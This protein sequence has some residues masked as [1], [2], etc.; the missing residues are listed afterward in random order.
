MKDAKRLSFFTLLCVLSVSAVSG[1]S[2][3]LESKWKKDFPKQISWYVRTSPGILLVKAGKDLI[4]LDG[5][6]GH[7]LWELPGAETSVTPSDLEVFQRGRNLIEVPGMGVLLLNRVKLSGNSDGRLVALNLLTGER[8]WDHPQVDNLMTALPLQGSRDI[9]IVSRR[10]QRKILVRN[11]ILTAGEAPMLLY[12]FR[13]EFQR[14]DPLTGKVQWSTEYPRIFNPGSHS[15]S[16]IGN[17]LFLDFGNGLLGCVDLANGKQLW[18]EGSK[19]IGGS[20]PLSLEAA[21]GNVIYALKNVRAVHPATNQISWQIDKLG[22][23]TG[24]SLHEDMVFAI[25]ENNLAAVDAKTGADRW[26][27]KTHGHTTNTLWDRPTDTIIYVDGKGLHRVE[28]ATGKS[29]LDAAL[30]A[31]Q[32]D[33]YH[34]VHIRLASREV[35]VMIAESGVSAYNFKTGKELFAAGKLVGFFPSYVFLD[36]WPMPP[37][38]G[39]LIPPVQKTSGA[40]D[41]D[42]TREG[43][44]LSGIAAGHLADYR[45]AGASI[46]DAYETESENGARKVWWID[47]DTNL[48]MG[49]GVAD[50]Q[51]DVSRQLGMVFAVNKNQIW[52]AAITAK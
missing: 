28:R 10:L 15:M 47:S 12:P 24:I 50:E 36:H 49:F 42:S 33:V 43:A 11:L 21:D 45:A 14:L 30:P 37:D 3:S 39:S 38:G 48:Q 1:H 7:Q 31:P 22:T 46:M 4:A 20:L 17:H 51:H 29:L 2:Q 40:D 5:I 32:H 44:L 23:I 6:D 8:L 16:L 35:V 52:G 25:G 41:W 27:K 18:E 26:R 19:V 13:F 34:P 9:V